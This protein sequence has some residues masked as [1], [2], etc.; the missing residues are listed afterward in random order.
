MEVYVKV[1][2]CFITIVC[3][4]EIPEHYRQPEQYL[5]T[6]RNL[7]IYSGW[8]TDDILPAVDQK[9]EASIYMK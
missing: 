7:A 9:R 4:A 5:L 3:L 1:P 8:N 6:C 2:L